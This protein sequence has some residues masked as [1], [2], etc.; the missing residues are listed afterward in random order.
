VIKKIKIKIIKKKKLNITKFANFRK[1]PLKKL[2]EIYFSEAEPNIWSTWKF[3]ETR[4]QYLTIA[5]GSV[6][7]LYKNKL[8]GKVK[9]ITINNSKKLFAL[10]IPQ[11][12]YYRFKCT[13]KNKALIINIIDEV[14]K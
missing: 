2:G 12:H 6:E 9:K 4:N 14:V 11:K 10:Y 8:N 13:S 7:F 1:I 3:Y 5:Y